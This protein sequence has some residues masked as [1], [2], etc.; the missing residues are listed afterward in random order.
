MSTSVP[1]VVVLVGLG[2]LQA[3]GGGGQAPQPATR[4]IEG[5]VTDVQGHPVREGKIMFAL[6][7]PPLAFQEA[8]TADIDQEG[9]YRIELSTLSLPPTLSL[10]LGRSIPPTG[11]LRCLVLVSGFRRGA[12]KVDAETGS[13]RVDIQLTPEEWRTTEIFLVDRDGKPVPGALVST[14]MG[15][16]A[17]WSRQTSDAQG[18]C[19]VKSAPGDVCTVS[20]EH[21]GY[22]PTEFLTRGTVADP[23]SFKVPLFAIIEGH[24]VDPAGKPLAGIQIG[25]V[26]TDGLV[27][28]KASE[29]PRMRPLGGVNGLQVTDAQG[30]FRLAPLV[31]LDSR[32]FANLRDFKIW[33]LAIC[34]AD[35]TMR[36]VFF[37]RV[38]VQSARRPYEITLRPGRAV[39][40]PIEHAV[41]V[42]NGDLLSRW[43]LHDLAGATDS[44]PGIRVMAGRVKHGPSGQESGTADWID[45]YLPEGRYRIEVDFAEVGAGTDAESLAT[46]IVVPPGEGPLSLPPL[47]MTVSPIRG[48]SGTPAPEIDA[49]DAQTGAPVKLADYR[50]K[51]VVLD[52]WGHWC[53][54]CLGAMPH[55]IDAH[56]RYRGKPV[57][58]ITLHDQSMQ[59]LDQLKRQLSG[60]KRQFW[61]DRELPFT[62]AFDRP[63]PA[64]AAGAAA[65]A[66]GTTIA[67]YK[68]NLFPTTL[69]IDQ[70]GKVVAPVDARDDGQLNAMIDKLL[71]K[72]AR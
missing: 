61:N 42:P 32:D 15:S 2:G 40:M 55:L 44:D 72:P 26:L 7:N 12:G 38:D 65:I 46:E 21:E 48:L 47:R 29:P 69:V 22:L 63:D 71:T 6:Q 23:T 59:S 18:R 25:S 20:V 50:G 33:P 53:G 39:R 56:E 57:V 45:E 60:V 58:I 68:I 13:A 35:E 27:V 43:S 31:R 67:R 9:H 11:R 37:L 4:L 51:V 3:P 70:D 49:K 5:R 64:V 62:V 34:F 17:V 30:K 8:W 28:A 54:P 52:F 19:L 16:R 24:V 14:K 36:R 10:P 1:I 41:V 66:R